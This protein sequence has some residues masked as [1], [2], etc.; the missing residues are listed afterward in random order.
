MGGGLAGKEGGHKGGGYFF[1]CFYTL[2]SNTTTNF[3]QPR[4]C[5]ILYLH[6]ACRAP[7]VR[8]LRHGGGGDL[9][10]TTLHVVVPVVLNMARGGPEGGELASDTVLLSAGNNVYHGGNES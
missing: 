3:S 2:L 8:Q 4:G 1:I 5:H 6:H 10:A 7:P 9:V